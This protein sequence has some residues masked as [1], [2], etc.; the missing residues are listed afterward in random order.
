MEYTPK[1]GIYVNFHY[2]N[3]KT[4]IIATYTMEV[5]TDLITARFSERTKGFTIVQ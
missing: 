1:I 5:E 3:A 2:N 4:L